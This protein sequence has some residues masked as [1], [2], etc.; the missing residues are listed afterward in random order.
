MA[1][2]RLVLRVQKQSGT[3]TLES[4][5]RSKARMTEL[6]KACRKIQKSAIT[7]DQSTFIVKSFEACRNT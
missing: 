7:Q 4:S 5:R 1:L 3:N 2:S 6:E